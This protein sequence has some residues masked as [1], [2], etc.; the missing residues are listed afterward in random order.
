MQID[1]QG[2]RYVEVEVRVPG[3]TEAV[4]DA[5]ASGPGVS[6]WFVPTEINV[7]PDG[8]PTGVVSHFGEGMDAVATVTDWEPP[9]RFSAVSEDFAPGGPPMTRRTAS[10]TDWA[11]EPVG[12]G[13]CIV[14]VRHSSR[15]DTDEWDAYLEGVR[16]AGLPSLAF[17]RPT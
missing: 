5:I 16:M 10:D 11:V 1:S 2:L 8:I 17:C 15:A 13:V 3:A 4:W 12:D 6:A 9:Q 7:G 14:R